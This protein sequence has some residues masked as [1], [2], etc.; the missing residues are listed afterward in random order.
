MSDANAIEVMEGLCDLA[1][2]KLAVHMH[3]K[4]QGHDVSVMLRELWREEAFL[5]RES[6]SIRKKSTVNSR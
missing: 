5:V 4:T 3:G 6:K 1:Q 2:G